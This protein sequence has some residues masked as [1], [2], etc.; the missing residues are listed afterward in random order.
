MLPVGISEVGDARGTG[1]DAGTPDEAR[2]FSSLE[3]PPTLPGAPM[4]ITV[5]EE[6]HDLIARK[7][8]VVAIDFIPPVG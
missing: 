5:T 3:Y 2:G 7:G 4:D 8:G 6:A 1:T